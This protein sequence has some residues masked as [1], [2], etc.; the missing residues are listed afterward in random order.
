M[1]GTIRIEQKAREP[2]GSEKPGDCGI[3][4]LGGIGETGRSK[5]PNVHRVRE[6][7]IRDMPRI[8]MGPAR[9]DEVLFLSNLNRQIPPKGLCEK[10]NTVLKG[11]RAAHK[12]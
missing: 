9:S 7:E 10:P 1:P 6:S 4:E 2:G 3:Q 5:G 12:T 8:A 11:E